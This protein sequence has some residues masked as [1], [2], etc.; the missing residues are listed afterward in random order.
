MTRELTAPNDGLGAAVHELAAGRAGRN[1]VEVMYAHERLP[2]E[3]N[4]PD[5]A[6]GEP[7]A[8]AR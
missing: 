2:Q 1:S 7:A 5:V 3:I 6:N 4:H 8:S